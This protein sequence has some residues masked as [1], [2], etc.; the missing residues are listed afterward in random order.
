[1]RS[2]SKILVPLYC[3]VLTAC[4][5]DSVDPPEDGVNV[6]SLQSIS[7]IRFNR[8]AEFSVTNGSESYSFQSGTYEYQDGVTVAN[9]DSTI[10][11]FTGAELGS[12]ET[13]LAT[14]SAQIYSSY[15]ASAFVSVD[16]ISAGAIN[17]QEA[18]LSYTNSSD[19]DIIEIARHYYV[20]SDR[21]F[22]E[23]DE[24]VVFFFHCRTAASNY[25]E[26]ESAMRSILNTV[27]FTSPSPSR[28]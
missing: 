13:T 1:M 12:A 26:N 25:S 18:I 23:T 14:A 8:P 28:E 20:P 6:Q 24:S 5:G 4:D 11:C 3:L 16:S 17:G 27:S 9:S 15:D 2:F 10:I 19:L 7:G 21:F 22:F